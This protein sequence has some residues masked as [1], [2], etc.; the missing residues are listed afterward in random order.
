MRPCF[1]PCF[2]FPRLAR[3][4]GSLP[5]NAI[6]L[7]LLLACRAE[8]PGKP[9]VTDTADGG[10]TDSVDT[11]RGKR[12]GEP[13]A[14]EVCDHAGVDED[15]D[16]LVNGQDDDLT[17]G[18]WHA[19]EDGDGYGD[20]AVARFSCEAPAGAL[21]DG[22]DCDDADADVYPGAEESCDGL[23]QD[24][25]G[26][27]DEDAGNPWYADADGD[28]YGDA[29]SATVACTAPAGTVGTGGDCDPAGRHPTRGPSRPGPRRRARRACEWRPPG[30][31][32][33]SVGAV[34]AREQES[35]SA[36]SSTCPCRCA[37]DGGLAVTS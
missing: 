6:F 4:G 19:D 25:D 20:P 2:R 31:R 16:G 26:A 36:N 33:V 7:L 37:G 1:I 30:A 8:P 13:G 11:G 14:A 24:C 17:D 18:T 35:S 3:R 10:T 22:S 21:A 12:R 23:D 27:V 32:A 9:G 28:G 15:C 29:V 34:L 5:V